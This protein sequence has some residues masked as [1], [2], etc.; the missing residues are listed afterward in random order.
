[1]S[2][3]FSMLAGKIEEAKAFLTD[4]RISGPEAS[5]AHSLLS[6]ILLVQNHKKEAAAEAARA[7]ELNNRSPLAGMTNALVK[8][9]WFDLP[10][11]RKYLEQALAEDPRFLQAYLYMARIWLG[12]DYLDRA[13]EC[14]TKALTISDTDGEVLSLAGFI[15][16]GYRDF[17]KAFNLFS[18]AVKA[19]PGFG[20]PHVGL[21]NI[22]FKNRNFSLGLTEM[23]TA[24]LLEP[25]VSLYQSSLG[26][27]LYQTRAFDKALEVYDYAK[28]LDPNDPTPYLYKGIALSDLNRPGEAI[29]ELNKSIQL[30]DNTAIFRSRLML[31]RDLAVRNTDLARAYGQLGLSDWSFSKALTAVKNDPLSP[32]AHLFLSSAFQSTRQRTGA[33][34]SEL[35][36][37]RL[38]APANENTFSVYSDYTPM[39]EMPYIRTQVGMGAGTWYD[40]IGPIQD[41][42]LEVFGGLPGLALD[43]YGAYSSDPGMRKINSD[44]NSYFGIVEGKYEPTIKDS[45]LASYLY[46]NTLTGDTGSQNDYSYVTDP[47][48]RWDDREQSVEGGFVHRFAPWSVF[49]AYFNYAHEDWLK[50]DR[51]YSSFIDYNNNMDPS[52]LYPIYEYFFDPT[53][54][55]TYRDW[56]NIQLQQQMRLGDHTVIAGMDYFS[57][58]LDYF[59]KDTAFAKAYSTQLGLWI[60]PPP[61]I[62]LDEKYNTPDDTFSVYMRDYWHITSKLLAEYGMSGDFAQNSRTGYSDTV[63]SVTANPFLGFDYELD[64]KNTLRLAFQQYVNTHSLFNASIAPTEVAG[65]PAQINADEGSK[66]KEVGLAW[67][68][69]WNPLTFTV[70]RFMGHHIDNPQFDPTDPT[71]NRLISVQTDRLMGSFTLNRL[72]TPYLGLVVGISGKVLSLDAPPDTGLPT[73]D[74]SEIDASIGLAY[75]HPSGW[76]ASITSTLVHQD[77]NGLSDRSIH[78]QQTA[79]AEDPFNLVNISFG[80]QFDLKRGFF[81]L[82]INNIFNQHFFYET[83]PVQLNAIYPDRQ[84]MFL[85]G[86][87]F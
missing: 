71:E 28:T 48:L 61:E 11:A 34:A 65:F 67:E 27:A 81:S 51:L 17:D 70:F 14:I 32:S 7:L 66:V 3:Y 47:N 85:L 9:A 31:D 43:F 2:G 42:N 6:Q 74:Y 49:L 84:I 69:Q 13:R 83:E 86:L 10:A 73:G 80:K 23:L 4:S 41:Y 25:R 44:T 87:Y 18:E 59:Y 76:F 19:D 36:L 56:H 5:M 68:A 29:Q 62:V 54:Y 15:Q 24:T 79:L 78:Q 46:S 57:G 26:K 30:N 12:S 22:A 37:Y 35:L 63:H 16:L 20:D 21:S 64:Q 55:H 52:H 82:N 8:I 50:T 53:N 60:I 39:F 77:L 40:H 33:A 1:M 75:Q 45:L 72:L 38:L 58:Y